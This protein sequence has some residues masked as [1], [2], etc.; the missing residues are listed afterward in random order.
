MTDQLE[1]TCRCGEVALAT[2]KY[3]EACGRPLGADVGA[4]ADDSVVTGDAMTAAVCARGLV[5]RRNEDAV[6]I[7]TTEHGTVAVVCDGVSSSAHGDVAA[8]VAAEAITAALEQQL[9]AGT[10]DLPG[11][12][13]AGQAAVCRIP[14][15]AD[16]GAAP[17]CTAIAAAIGGGVIQLASVGDCRAYWVSPSGASRLT[18][19]DSVSPGSHTITRWLGLDAPDDPITPVR[20]EPTEGGHVVLCS[21]GLWNVLDEPDDLASAAPFGSGAD[22]RELAGV[23]LRRA[24]AA[25]GRD[26]ISVAVVAV[27]PQGARP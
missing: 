15:D 11:A 10:V 25:G 4:P 21:D 14:H 9:E 24:L 16:D 5:R 2:D 3:C 13:A 6:R 26:N 20:M 7:R 22:C 23:L 27:E 8:R 1:R 19:D 18:D 17:S 12:F